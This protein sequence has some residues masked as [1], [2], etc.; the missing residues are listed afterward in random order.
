MGWTGGC[1][2]LSGINWHNDAVKVLLL[3]TL[4]LLLVSFILSALIFMPGADPALVEVSQVCDSI[5][6]WATI[7]HQQRYVK[8]AFHEALI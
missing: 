1:N 3:T 8:L 5:F 2:L 4:V 6:Y 7:Y